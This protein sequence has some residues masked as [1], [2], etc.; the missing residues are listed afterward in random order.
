MII[1]I[2]AEKVYDKIQHTFMIKAL[3][4]AG[5]EGTYLNIIKAIYD[6]PTANIILNGEK[7]KTFPLHTH[8]HTNIKVPCRLDCEHCILLIYS[9]I[10][11]ILQVAFLR[12][13]CQKW[14]CGSIYGF[15]LYF[16][17]Q[18]PHVLFSKFI[19]PIEEQTFTQNFIC[20]LKQWLPKHLYTCLLGHI[21]DNQSVICI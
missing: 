4:K 15:N 19:Y 13:T 17:V 3:Q 21:C 10:H 2:D 12:D 18:V 20:C 11:I 1:S 5:I 16:M 6:K 9:L 14:I 7:L 8:T